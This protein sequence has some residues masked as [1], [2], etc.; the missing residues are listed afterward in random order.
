MNF[1]VC[2]YSDGGTQLVGWAYVTNTRGKESVQFEYSNEW[3]NYGGRYAIE[4]ALPLTKGVFHPPAGLGMHG[5]LGDSTPDSWGRRLMQRAE[6]KIAEREGRTV[7]TLM[8][9]DFLLGVSDV[10]R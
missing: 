3:L 2:T 8:G 10:S 4:P 1:G 5:S 7:R 6:R 9:T